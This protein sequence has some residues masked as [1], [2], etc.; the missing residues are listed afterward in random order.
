V[1]ASL[2]IAALVHQ[3]LGDGTALVPAPEDGTAPVGISQAP[4]VGCSVA[5]DFTPGDVTRQDPWRLAT[6]NAFGRR[7]ASVSHPLTQ[8]GGAALL[9]R[10]NLATE[11]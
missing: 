8:F 10:R 2:G 9:R 5:C 1:S 3:A 11:V 6:A 4:V 7:H